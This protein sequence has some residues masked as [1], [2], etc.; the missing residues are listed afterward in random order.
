MDQ[1]Q[2]GT[3]NPCNNDDNCNKP[4]KNQK[5]KINYD[6]INRLYSFRTI[7]KLQS[8]EKECKNN[9]YCYLKKPDE[10]DKILKFKQDE[11]SIKVPFVIYADSVSLLKN[12]KK[13]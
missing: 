3:I 6:Y 13:M 5:S 2:K 12:R 4:W 11:K 1:K 9:D 7:K 10:S 8:H